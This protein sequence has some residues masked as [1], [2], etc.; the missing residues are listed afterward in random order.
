MQCSKVVPGGGVDDD[1]RNS[2]MEPEGRSRHTSNHRAALSRLSSP[3]PPHLA[4]SLVPDGDG[5][6]KPTK[7][8]HT[9]DP[10]PRPTLQLQLFNLAVAPTITM[11]PTG[12]TL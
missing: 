10:R 7:I 6:P 12:P 1:E 2:N 11:P 8:P 4:P 5:A 9:H 3:P